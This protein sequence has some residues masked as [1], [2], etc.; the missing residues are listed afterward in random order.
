MPYLLD[1]NNLMGKSDPSAEDRDALIREV[2]ERLRR[3]RA[4]AVLFF[5]GAARRQSRLGALTI[6]DGFGVNADEEILSSIGQARSAHEITVVTSDAGLARR[7]RDLGAAVLAPPEFW[8]RFGKPTGGSE[9][10]G[11]KVDVEDW[12]RYFSDERNRS[13]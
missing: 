5:D 2:A 6:R 3:T 10:G 8:N 7:S 9:K 13:D 4:S 11:E 1:G 12:E